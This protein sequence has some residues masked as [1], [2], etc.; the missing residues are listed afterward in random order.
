MNAA[1]AVAPYAR[2][3]KS[4][5]TA[6]ILALL[7]GNIGAHKF[8]LG[9]TGWGVLYLLFCWTFIPAVVALIEAI[10]YGA[11]GSENFHHKYG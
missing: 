9:R 6:I 5:G 1:V 8:Y 2:P 3:A 4:R 10:T 11:S 7:L